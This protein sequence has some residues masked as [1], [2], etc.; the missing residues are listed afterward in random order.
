MSASASGAAAGG[1]GVSS[2]GSG[3]RR[4]VSGLP[5]SSSAGASIACRSAAAC[6]RRRPSA[7]VARCSSIRRRHAGVCTLCSADPWPM[8]S[9]P[10][11][12]SV[13]PAAQKSPSKSFTPLVR[14]GAGSGR[15]ISMSCMTLGSRR[16]GILASDSPGLGWISVPVTR[17]SQSRSH[18]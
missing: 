18:R 13:K 9:H 11:Q 5:V 2:E 3:C 12:W 10:R 7:E 4:G 6:S 16:T 17:R 1:A 15:G 14:G 8:S